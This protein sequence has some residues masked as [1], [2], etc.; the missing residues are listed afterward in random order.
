[1]AR[2]NS[3]IN[4]NDA[5]AVSSGFP[6]KLKFAP[7]EDSLLQ[8]RDEAKAIACILLS[9]LRIRLAR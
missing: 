3:F 7:F 8:K 6:F 2:G 5:A 1:M 9:D 4:W